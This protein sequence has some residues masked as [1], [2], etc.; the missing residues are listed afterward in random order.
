[1]TLVT[2]AQKQTYMSHLSETMAKLRQDFADLADLAQLYSDRGYDPY[3]AGT[4]PI[5]DTAANASG[6]TSDEIYYSLGFAN[7]VATF[8]SAT[9]TGGT[10]THRAL[11][12]QLRRDK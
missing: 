9:V 1:M 3:H 11:I 2:S 5:D 8:L 12:N 4:D 6:F 10:A 7:D